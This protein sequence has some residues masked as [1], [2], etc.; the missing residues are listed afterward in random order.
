M[1]GKAFYSFELLLLLQSYVWFIIS[2]RGDTAEYFT[3]GPITQAKSG[4]F[5]CVIRLWVVLAC[6][7]LQHHHRQ[8]KIPG[9]VNGRQS[10]PRQQLCMLQTQT[11]WHHSCLPGAWVLL[12]RQQRSLMGSCPFIKVWKTIYWCCHIHIGKLVRIK[13]YLCSFNGRNNMRFQ[14]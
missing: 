10:F 9:C 6:R 7:I 12:H 1:I 2:N 14:R 3:V 8:V 13:Y 5:L 11:Y 4:V